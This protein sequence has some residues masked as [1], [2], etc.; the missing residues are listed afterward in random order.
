MTKFKKIIIGG[1]VGLITFGGLVACKGPGH[2]G[3]FAKGG[4]FM[5]KRLD[6]NEEQKSKM[7]RLFETIKTEVETHKANQPKQQIIAL[8]A[9]PELNQGKALAMLEQ[10]TDK[11][12]E[13]APTV[14][15]AIANFTNSLDDKQRTQL[16]EMLKKSKPSGRHFG[17]RPF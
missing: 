2:H 4:E 12:K 8:L 6:L 13:S 1:L 14:I 7:T 3:G 11:I 9:E 10:R 15:A 17:G 5:A 16:Q